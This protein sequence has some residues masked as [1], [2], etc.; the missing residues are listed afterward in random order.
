VIEIGAI[1]W[2][3]QTSSVLK[4]MS[5]LCCDQHTPNPIPEEAAQH[6]GLTYERLVHYGV[7]NEVAFAELQSFLQRAEAVVAHFGA[8]FDQ[9]FHDA[10]ILR[11]G[12]PRLGLTWIDTALD[13][14]YPD[15]IKTRSLLCL[16]AEHGFLNPFPHRAVFDVMTMLRI[17]SLYDP[18]AALEYARQPILTL[19]ALV[20]FD[21][22]ELA[23]ARAYRWLPAPGASPG[24]KKKWLKELRESDAAKEIADAGFPVQI[25][26]KKG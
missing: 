7:L 2:D 26:H 1:L 6:H 18:Q 22:K 4:L 11:I 13:I 5:C 10:E 20:S 25:I 15:R 14:K 24:A 23:K 21:D 8:K 19:E 3:T 16:A 17:F 12:L 9:D